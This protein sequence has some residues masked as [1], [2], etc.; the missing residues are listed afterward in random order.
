MA[1]A[2]GGGLT[3]GATRG[4]LRL[5]WFLDAL[6]G[7]LARGRGQALLLQLLL[8]LR[9]ELGGFRRVPCG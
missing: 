3:V 9:L 1:V 8:I 4:I 7:G 6:C 2:S 5:L